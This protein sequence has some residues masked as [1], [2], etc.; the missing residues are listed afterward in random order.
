MSDIIYKF[1]FSTSREYQTGAFK[2]ILKEHQSIWKQKMTISFC[3]LLSENESDKIQID[4]IHLNSDI[5]V[6]LALRYTFRLLHPKCVP[7]DCK[8]DTEYPFY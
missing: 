4:S 7:F 2:M 3:A 1:F 5:L 6:V 8:A